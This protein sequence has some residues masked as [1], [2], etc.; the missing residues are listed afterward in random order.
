MAAR[1][2]SEYGSR[3]ESMDGE[4]ALPAPHL[5]YLAYAMQLAFYA[6]IA[7]ALLGFHTH[8]PEPMASFVAE[9]KGQTMMCLFIFNVCIQG[10]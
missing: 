9:N 7:C 2:R 3:I 10:D 4:N 1:V 8:L 5:M 6:G